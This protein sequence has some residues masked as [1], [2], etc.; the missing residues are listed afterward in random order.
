MAGRHGQSGS[1]AP[2]FGCVLPP[3]TTVMEAINDLPRLVSGASAS[4]YRDDL[5]LTDY[6]RSMRGDCEVL[7]LHEATNHSP[8]MLEIIRHSGHNRSAI[9][10]GLTKSG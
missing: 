8:K 6:E 10:A 3:A 7:T 9:P 2:L 4:R 5:V 1:D